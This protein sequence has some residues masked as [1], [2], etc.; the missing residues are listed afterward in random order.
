M[1]RVIRLL[2]HVRTELDRER[3]TANARKEV[4]T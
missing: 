2:A 3:R 1:A 4:A